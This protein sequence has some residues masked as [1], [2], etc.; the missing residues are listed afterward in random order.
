[1]HPRAAELIESLQLAP[2]PEGGFYRELFR[3]TARVLRNDNIERSAV[4]T[5]YFLL[6]AGSH[7]RWH[8]VLADEIWHWYEGDSLELLAASADFTVI[9]RRRLGSVTIGQQ[10]ALTVPAG[11]W[12][13]ARPCG[14]YAFVGCTVAPGFEF[15]DF[16]FLREDAAALQALQVAA[17]DL[18]ALV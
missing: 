11:W 3:S 16:S 12:Q 4:T 10:P 8:R 15:K 1:M 18:A 14:S 7:S 13:A 17:P 2:H 6:T 5:I 9:E